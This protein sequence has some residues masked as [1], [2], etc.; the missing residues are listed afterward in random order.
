MSALRPQPATTGPR[1]FPAPRGV[2]LGALA[3]LRPRQWTKNLLLFAG[4]IFAEH[5]GQPLAWARALVIAVAYCAASS[6]AYLV[7]DVLDREH[8]RHHPTKRFRPIARGELSPTAALLTA[9]ALLA[10]GLAVAAAL[11]TASLEFLVAFAALQGA[12]SFGLKRVVGIDVLVIAGLFVIRA[13]AGA[14][15]VGVRISPW[16]LACT[17]LLALFLALSKR[18][19]ELGLVARTQTPGRP[20]L[21]GY[22]R[23]VI[24]PLAVIAATAAGLAYAVYTVNGSPDSPQM[25][26]TIPFVW[27]GIARYL[28]LVARRDLGEEPEQV[29]LTDRLILG[30]VAGFGLTATI[31][32][33]IV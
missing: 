13:A 11:G 20:V 26:V 4:L 9:A 25:A 16:L 24:D 30:S 8:D 18:R 22:S 21:A 1:G 6:S 7:N 29:L 5:Y 14:A 10:G 2:A 12:Y 23:A 19:S 17:A 27:F 15:A 32:L 3:A 31:V 33:A 28:Y